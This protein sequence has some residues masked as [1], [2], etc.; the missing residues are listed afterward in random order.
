MQDGHV[1]PHVVERNALEGGVLLGGPPA[2]AVDP[3]DQVLLV[4]QKVKRGAL[5][6]HEVAHSAFDDRTVLEGTRVVLQDVHPDVEV[7]FRL[8]TRSEH[9]DLQPLHDAHF[10]RQILPAQN[11]LPQLACHNVSILQIQLDVGLRTRH[12]ILR[13]RNLLPAVRHLLLVEQRNLPIAN[14][15]RAVRNLQDQRFRKAALRG[16][17]NHRR[18]DVGDL[19]LHQNGVLRV[20]HHRQKDVDFER[21]RQSALRDRERGLEVIQLEPAAVAGDDLAHRVGLV[22][23]SGGARR[24]QRVGRGD[25]V[26]GV[27]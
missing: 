13:R 18:T 6:D 26:R 15:L 11:V 25:G 2:R 3:Q 19:V 21:L 8:P 5:A 10:R 12:V 16:P 27:C 20:V 7:R 1:L 14:V 22:H 4:V 23:G 17:T 9:V 24:F